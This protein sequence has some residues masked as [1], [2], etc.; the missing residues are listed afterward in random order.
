MDKNVDMNG[1]WISV[2][3]YGDVVWAPSTTIALVL[4]EEGLWE[5]THP[6]IPH[7]KCTLNELL[8][9]SLELARS[10]GLGLVA[11]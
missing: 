9:I 7:L 8:F 4:G 2:G 11:F 6:R 10:S 5:I 1:H 3:V